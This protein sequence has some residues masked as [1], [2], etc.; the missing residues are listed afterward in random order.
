[1]P[2]GE[3]TSTAAGCQ[4]QPAGYTWDAIRAPLPIGDEALRILGHRSGAALADPAARYMYWFVAP[5]TAAAWALVGTTALGRGVS[6]VVPKE[7]KTGPPGPHWRVCP[8]DG[9]LI[10]HADA[11][12][13]ALQ[14]AL[15]AH[16]TP[17]GTA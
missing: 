9:A 17:G 8:G 5:G 11:L 7:R 15:E 13:A 14:D 1:M 3:A 6:I 2:H 10:T 12:L 4:L 16:A